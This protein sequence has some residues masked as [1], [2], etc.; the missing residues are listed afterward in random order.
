[1]LGAEWGWEAIWPSLPLLVVKVDIPI[2]TAFHQRR[3]VIS[4]LPTYLC[5]LCPVGSLAAS[6][7]LVHIAFVWSIECPALDNHYSLSV[8]SLK[9]LF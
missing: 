2:C 8:F 1:M 6:L 4:F 7:S 9:Q 3:P 5:L